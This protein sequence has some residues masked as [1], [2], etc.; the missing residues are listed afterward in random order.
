M[1]DSY[2]QNR[3][4]QGVILNRKYFLICS[5]ATVPTGAFDSCTE[6]IKFTSRIW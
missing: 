2:H 5:S 6:S 1:H 3:G 4:N